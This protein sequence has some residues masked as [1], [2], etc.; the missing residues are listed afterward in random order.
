VPAD[1]DDVRSL[2]TA[3][4]LDKALYEVRYELN[5][6]PDWSA[7]PLRGVLQLIQAEEAAPS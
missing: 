3:Y 1:R 5:N 7:I 4:T 6:R 2:L